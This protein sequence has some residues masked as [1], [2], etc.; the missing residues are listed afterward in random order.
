MGSHAYRSASSLPSESATS[1]AAVRGRSARIAQSHPP[2]PYRWRLLR[3]H[4]QHDQ[5]ARYHVRV[6]ACSAEITREGRGRVRTRQWT[7]SSEAALRPVA[8]G[9]PATTKLH[10]F[11]NVSFAVS[12]HRAHKRCVL[13]LAVTPYRL[14][15]LPPGF[16]P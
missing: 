8:P 7:A 13:A 3:P 5:D 1:T 15:E 2:L 16:H 10:V 9:A 12:G 11:P 14:C 4:S 6:A